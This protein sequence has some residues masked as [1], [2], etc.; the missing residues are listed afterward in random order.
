VND[1]AAFARLIRALRPWLGHLVI[2]GGWDNTIVM[3]RAKPQY[4]L[5]ELVEHQAAQPARRDELGPAGRS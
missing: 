5:K 1:T 3:R 4:S 2:V